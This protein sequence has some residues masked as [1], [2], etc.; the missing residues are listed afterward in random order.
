[1][2]G[3]G[4]LPALSLFGNKGEMRYNRNKGEFVMPAL[5]GTGP[6]GRGSRTGRGLGYCPPGYGRRYLSRGFRGFARGFGLGRGRGFGR[7]W[8]WPLG[9][10][11]TDGPFYQEPTAKE[12]KEMLTEE[13]KRLKE[14][15]KEIEACLEELKSKK[16]R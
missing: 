7:G 6:Q 13:L 8:R 16:T 10:Y 9:G 11:P 15:M 5:N 12:E 3:R 14:E 1:L 2:K 4:H